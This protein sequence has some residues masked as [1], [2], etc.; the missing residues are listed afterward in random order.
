VDVDDGDGRVRRAT[1][2]KVV[3]ATGTKPARP[4]SVEFDN[5]TVIDSDGSSTWSRCHARWWSRA[6]A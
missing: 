6:P 5:R 3:I 2:D 4:A 1:A